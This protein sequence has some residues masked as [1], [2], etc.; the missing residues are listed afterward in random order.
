MAVLAV[1]AVS[2][3]FLTRPDG[4]LLLY[5]RTDA[6]CGG[7]IVYLVSSWE[8]VRMLKSPL[9]QAAVPA[10]AAVTLF[11]LLIL[12]AVTGRVVSFNAGISAVIAVGFVM[13][14]HFEAGW[15]AL[16]QRSIPHAVV[17]WIAE[18][19]FSI[20]VIHCISIALT[21]EIWW[22]LSGGATPNATFTFKFY[23]TWIALT[24]LFCELNWRYVET[25][26]RLKGR[27]IA[28]RWFSGRPHDTDHKPL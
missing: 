22:H 10:R 6:L 26:L 14:A 25:P 8:G 9:S 12:T 13:I 20:Y 1:I 11:M 27:R 21:R 18:R 7:I 3:L 24:L 15:F 16:P 4:S 5:I 28:T 19:S 23:V 17:K 2:Q